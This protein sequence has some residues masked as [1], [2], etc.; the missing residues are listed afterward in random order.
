M[1][2][3]GD[4][5]VRDAREAV[6]TGRA[7]R[8]DNSFKRILDAYEAAIRASER[9]RYAG[10]VRGLVSAL[11]EGVCCDGIGAHVEPCPLVEARVTLAALEEA[12]SA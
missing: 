10:L 12:E 4:E 11:E 2:E 6:L 7:S 5:A 3:P 1:P 8:S 9:E